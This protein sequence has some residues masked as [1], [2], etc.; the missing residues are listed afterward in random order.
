MKTYK[1][2]YPRVYAFDNLYCAF[3]RARKGGKRRQP[4]VAAFE[5][6][7]EPELWRLHREL[8][9]E[10]YCPGPYRNFYIY[11]RKKRKISAAPF[12]DRVVHHA[13]CQVIGPIFERRMIHD[14]Y[15]CRVDKGTHRAADRAQQFGRVNRY[16][17]P[18][19]IVQFFPSIDHAILRD[20]L[21][22]PLADPQVMGLVDLILASGRGILDSEYDLCWFPGDDLW[23]PAE[24]PRGL[25]IGNLTSQFWANCYLDPFD[26]FIKRELGCRGYVRYVDDLALFADDKRTLWAWRAALVERLAGLRLTIHPG[27]QPRPVT[28]GLPFLGFVV[29]PTHRR[30]KRRNVVKF[31]RRLRGLLAAYEAGEAPL[32]HVTASIQGWINHARYGD[33]WG[34]RRAVYLFSVPAVAD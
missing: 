14:S 17:L 26:Q 20:I 3:R 11:E 29:Y 32:E 13:L 23:T 15:A 19:D 5:Y 21:A 31:R 27:A 18:C 30:L 4:E 7:L 2:L 9:A 34:L 12:R 16:L 24:R 25:P 1:H 33:T 22:R 10:T 28:E 6:H 8:R